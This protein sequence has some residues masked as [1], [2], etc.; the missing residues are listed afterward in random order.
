MKKRDARSGKCFWRFEKTGKFLEP[1]LR[2][3]LPSLKDVTSQFEVVLKNAIVCT[4]VALRILKEKEW[5]RGRL[6]RPRVLHMSKV[7][8]LR[9]RTA[10]SEQLAYESSFYR[11]RSGDLWVSKRNCMSPAE[12]RFP[13][14]LDEGG[15]RLCFHTPQ[16]WSDTE[17]KSDLVLY[18]STQP[19]R[20]SR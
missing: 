16:N 8:I 5:R 20:F 4:N 10:K 9:S 14:K 3:A 19:S 12:F 18:E 15:R 1:N 2:G 6:R 13:K 17:D 11:F 7:A